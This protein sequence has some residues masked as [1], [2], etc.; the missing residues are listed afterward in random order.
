VPRFIEWDSLEVRVDGRKLNEMARAA[1][2]AEPMIERLELKFENGLLRVEGSIR[3]FISV[4]FTVEI[5]RIEAKGLTVRVP[6]ARI[7]A[8]S[9]PIPTLLVGLLRKRLPADLVQYEEPATLVVSLV[10][11]L[12]P[13][14]SADI[15][16]IWII[17]GGLAVTLGRGGAD[18]PNDAAEIPGG[19]NGREPAVR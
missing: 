9:I 18:L 17:A 19:L 16:K 13:F 7:S 3:K 2:A 1:V 15:Q 8:G 4:P 6:L 5:P 10:R 12:P 14:V 11:F